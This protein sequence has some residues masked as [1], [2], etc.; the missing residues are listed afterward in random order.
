MQASNEAK[1][2]NE[3]NVEESLVQ[4]LSE[5]YSAVDWKKM[6]KSR[7]SYYDIFEHRL[8]FSRYEKDIPSLLNRLCN[9]LS[10]QAPPLSLDEIEF[11]RLH[12]DVALS[13][14]RKMP[15][16]L[17]LKAADKTKK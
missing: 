4:V 8:S 2:L 5:I 10:L 1:K 12:E 15:K 7:S 9:S 16:L 11:L 3:E 17:T 13:I 14:V 6:R